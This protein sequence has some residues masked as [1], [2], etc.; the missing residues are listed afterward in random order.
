MIERSAYAACLGLVL[1]LTGCASSPPM[2]SAPPAQGDASWH[3]VVPPDTTRYPL[4]AGEISA[5]GTPIQRVAPVYPAAQLASCPP[6]QEVQALLIVGDDG[7]VAEVRVA[8]EALATAA[9]RSFIAATRA[10]ALQW[11]F[12]PLQIN[13]WASNAAGESHLV[14]STT[15]PF[16]LAYVFSFSCRGGTAAVSTTPDAK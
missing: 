11:E 2:P 16:S 3:M 8:D 5:G 15:R 9:R 12:S 13:H 6:P 7:N 4:A 10:A 14:D 1:L